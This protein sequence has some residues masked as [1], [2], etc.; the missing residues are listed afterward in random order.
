[1][2]FCGEESQ[3]TD[4]LQN[5]NQVSSYVIR[6]GQLALALPMDGGIVLFDPVVE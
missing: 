6:D 5:L 3:D 2:M 4:Y 1:M